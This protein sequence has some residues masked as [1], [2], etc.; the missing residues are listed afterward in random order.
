MSQAALAKSIRDAL[1]A[2]Q[3]AGT[4]YDDVS[5]VIRWMT[6]AIGQSLPMF[7]YQ[8][9]GDVPDRFFAGGDPREVAVQ[10]DLYTNRND[11]PDAHD[12]TKVKARA[13]LDRQTLTAVGFS[14]VQCWI[15]DFG[16]PL[17]EDDALHSTM[18]GTLLVQ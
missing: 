18:F 2:S 10:F 13:L 8:F 9:V 15:D 1:S 4:F 6:G 7:T 3:V 5:G 16:S 12:A 17:A 14:D 11:G